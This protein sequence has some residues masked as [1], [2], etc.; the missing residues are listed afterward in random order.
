MIFL[1]HSAGKARKFVFI[2]NLKISIISLISM[3]ECLSTSCGAARFWHLWL[4]CARNGI[5]NKKNMRGGCRLLH[6]SYA[7]DQLSGSRS[8]WIRPFFSLFFLQFSG[9]LRIRIILTVPNPTEIA[10]HQKVKESRKHWWRKVFVVEFFKLVVWLR[11][12]Y[13]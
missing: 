12:D 8:C 13:F 1:C 10:T 7:T 6:L 4:Q 11:N 5:K 3:P 2:F 9:S